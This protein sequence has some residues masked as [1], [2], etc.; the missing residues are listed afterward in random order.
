MTTYYETPEGFTTPVN[1]GYTKDG[2]FAVKRADW[3]CMNPEEGDYI[4]KWEDLRTGDVV[5]SNDGTIRE[6]VTRHPDGGLSVIRD[7]NCRGER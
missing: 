5:I 1:S 4:H 6:A 3:L 2:F 7:F